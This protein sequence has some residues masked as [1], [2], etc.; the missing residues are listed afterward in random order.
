MRRLADDGRFG[1]R[2]EPALR[3]M[4]RGFTAGICRVGGVAELSHLFDQDD[5]HAGAT[6][7]DPQ[8]VV[9]VER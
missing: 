6:P 2:G 3:S 1:R 8:A 5:R 9:E 4:Q 7:T